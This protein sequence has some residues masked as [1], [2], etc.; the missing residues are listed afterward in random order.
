MAFQHQEK[1]DG[2]GYPRQLMSAEIHEYAKIVA[3][4]DVYDAITSDR[5]YHRGLFPHEA[6]MLLAEGMGKQFDVDVLTA[7]LT[8][9]AIYSIGSVVELSTGEIGVV[10]NV[11]WGMQNRPT[12]RLM[13]DKNGKPLDRKIIVDLLEHSAI[14]IERVLGEEDMAELN[15]MAI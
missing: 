3:V 5:P 6:A 15:K 1:P 4:A 12:I 13:L 7:F 11:F 8:R 10:T 2:T 14:E 9:V